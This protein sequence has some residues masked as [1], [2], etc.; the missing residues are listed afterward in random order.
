MGS[1]FAWRDGRRFSI[2]PHFIYSAMGNFF[3]DKGSDFFSK[4]EILDVL[5]PISSLVI[6]DG[7]NL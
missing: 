4:L 5:D 2:G 3:G 7:K 1:K 6:C